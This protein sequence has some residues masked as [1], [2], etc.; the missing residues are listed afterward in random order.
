M[1]PYPIELVSTVPTVIL[2]GTIVIEKNTSMHNI[3][4]PSKKSVSGVNL[5][6]GIFIV[7]VAENVH[8]HLI[9][10]NGEC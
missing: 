4:V 8:T 6:V 7:W 10:I 3:Y 5:G 9:K 2:L 1:F